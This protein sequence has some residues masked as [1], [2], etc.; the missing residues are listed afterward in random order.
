MDN[1][2]EINQM[3]PPLQNPP[4]D[5]LTLQLE[6][7]LSE[8]ALFK[9]ALEQLPLGLSMFDQHDV[10][11]L[12]N[13]LYGKLYNLTEDLIQPGTSFAEIIANTEGS[14]SAESRAQPVP[15]NGGIRRREWIL[16]TG[17]VIEV[18]VTRRVD[19]SCIALHRDITEH[20]LAEE[21]IAFLAHH[22]QLTDLPNRRA[23]T[24]KLEEYIS[25]PE[26]DTEFVIMCMDLDRFKFVNDTYGHAIGDELLKQVA[27]RLESCVRSTDMVVRLG[28]DEFMV[29]Q[30]SPGR[31]S[32]CI[33]TAT[34]IVAELS[35]PYLISGQHIYIGT[36]I[37]IAS[38]PEDAASV[39]ELLNSADLAL[40]RAKSA[41]RGTYRFFEPEMDEK[42]R[43]RRRLL[44]GLRT[45]QQNNELHLLYQPIVLAGNRKVEAFEALLRWTHPEDGPISPAEFIPLAEES[46][47][48]I[49][50]GLWVLSQACHT[51]TTLPDNVSMCVNVSA[52][53]LFQGDLAGD[54]HHC[55]NATGLAPERLEIEVTESVM[56]CHPQMAKQT[57]QKIAALGVRIAIDDFGTG[58]SSLSYLHQYPID[59]LKI[60]RSFLI[61][62]ESQENARTVI[63]AVIQLGLNLGLKVTIEGIET[64]AQFE[65][66]HLSGA[67]SVQGFY[68]SKPAPLKMLTRL[69][70]AQLPSAL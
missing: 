43:Q 11:V 6:T 10:L 55:L 53:Q 19:G 31:S 30:K 13:K 47:L 44:M 29:M 4:T 41:G 42:V 38:F 49:D 32:V 20:K 50:I 14:E 39:E 21:K 65:F 70:G 61:N 45:A 1:D 8:N 36:S 62:M 60:D 23:M 34:R 16:K 40:Y 9:I 48:I 46:G 37:G 24:Q 58:Y 64:H 54:I 57:L 69:A 52:V 28:G 12:A 3:E 66:A 22:D 51:A 68:F 5:P 35:K 26:K 25:G 63:H 15:V 59:R 18:V 33:N 67:L 7:L 27:A 56:M 17:R 2:Y